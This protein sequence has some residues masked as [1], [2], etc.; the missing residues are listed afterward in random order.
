M[1]LIDRDIVDLV[2]RYAVISPFEPDMLSGCSYDL[3]LGSEIR[4][5]N[6]KQKFELSQERNEFHIEAGECITFQTLE[7]LNFREPPL[8]GFVVNKHTMLARGIVHPTTKIDPGFKG[9]LAVT[10]FNQGGPA[11]KIKFGQPMAALIVYPLQSIPD[12]I[13]GDTQKPTA[14]EGAT[15]IATVVDEP[16]GPLDDEGLSK[17]YGK[18]L[19]RL[20]E[21]VRD[22]EKIIQQLHK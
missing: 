6:R 21:R 3:R 11:E 17:M 13:Y 14:R 5:R 18:P 8:F 20:Y 12:R 15:E 4:S 16:S 7:E 22:L 1:P 2:H 19:W 9:S 10:I